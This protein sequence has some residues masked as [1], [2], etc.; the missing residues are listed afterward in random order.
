MYRDPIVVRTLDGRPVR[1]VWRQRLY[2]VLGVLEHWI[3]SR[4]WWQQ[5]GAGNGVPPE[6]EFWRVEAS[7][8]QDV[9]S[10]VYELRRDTGSGDWMLAR[11]WD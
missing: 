2:T 1:F 8:G 7:P 6:R 5:Q 4:R 9:P 10:A 11:V 3:V